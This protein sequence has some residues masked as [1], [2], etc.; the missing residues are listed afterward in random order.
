MPISVSD[1]RSNANEQIDHVV[2]KLG[3]AAQR[4]AVFK[5]IY[6][7]KSKIKTVGELARAARLSR[8]RGLQ[9]GGYLA[10]NFIVSQTRKD[11]DTAYEK[12]TFIAAQ[13]T[14]ILRLVSDPKKRA[15]L[16]TKRRPQVPAVRNVV[17]LAV[18][19]KQV[20]VIPVTIDDIDSF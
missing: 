6:R 15:K 2:E 4:L 19:K 20:Q 5:A 3:R 12:D 16:P 7:G 1:A 17:H 8:I 14:K 10:A 11:D 9:E 18:P 13:R